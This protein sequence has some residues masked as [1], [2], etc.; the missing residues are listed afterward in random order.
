MR[1]GLL[2]VA[3]PCRD[4]TERD[5]GLSNSHGRPLST[6]AVSSEPDDILGIG[7]CETILGAVR[8][9]RAKYPVDVHCKVI[10]LGGIDGE[11][12]IEVVG[13]RHP[14]QER[15][16]LIESGFDLS[17]I[18]D[19][20]PCPGSLCG[21]PDG[22]WCTRGLSFAGF[23]GPYDT[24]VVALSESEPCPHLVRPPNHL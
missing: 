1:D 22:C 14:L 18:A 24:T 11:V 23:S 6:V 4:N 13:G 8:V 7:P 20:G 17:L 3:L 19:S 16:A 15:T 5:V 21:G 2:K 12:V 9:V 10:P